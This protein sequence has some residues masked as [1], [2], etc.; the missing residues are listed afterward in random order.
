MI[1]KKKQ[2]AAPAGTR[3]TRGV[4]SFFQLGTAVFLTVVV[5]F[6]LMT[7]LSALLGYK[8]E[9]ADSAGG[10]TNL[11][12]HSVVYTKETPAGQLKTGD[13]FLGDGK[14]AAYMYIIRDVTKTGQFIT[15][16]A[17]D[18]DGKTTTEVI[19][20]PV[21]KVAVI[22]NGLG[23]FYGAVDGDTA[24][25]AVT[26]DFVILG[27][28]LIAGIPVTK[29]LIRMQDEEAKHKTGTTT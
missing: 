15:A 29:S 27:L 11:T 24:D 13:L 5:L 17:S 22:V 7:A 8:T 1:Q 2:A 28:V 20:K 10:L 12:R 6:F 19:S 21:N 9:V 25:L 3:L 23:I 18:P 26:I 14:N 16:S 4:L